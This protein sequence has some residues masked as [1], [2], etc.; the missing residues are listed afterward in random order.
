MD[1]PV[2]EMIMRTGWMGKL[3][4]GLLMIFSL[5]S[6]AI[7]FSR[8]FVLKKISV[9]NKQFRRRYLGMQRLSEIDNMSHRDLNTPLAQLGRVGAVEYRRILEDAQSHTGVK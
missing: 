3:I 4:I 8:L 1:I 2:L 6:W 9:G 7:V 5:I